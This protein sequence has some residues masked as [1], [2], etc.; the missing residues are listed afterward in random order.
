MKI[1]IT[2]YPTYGGSGIIATELG[3]NLAERGHNVHFIS[4]AMP[5]RLHHYFHENLYFHEVETMKY[6]L[7][8]HPPYAI[9]LA[10][11]MTDI[12]RHE[13][14]DLLHVHYAIPHATSAYLA[15]QA[16]GA[17]Q[18]KVIT[19]LH[20]TDI[21]IVGT[22]S[23]FLPITQFSIEK[24]DGVTTISRW[25]QQETITKLGINRELM[26][27]P[28]FIDTELFNGEIS[29]VMKSY[30]ICGSHKVLIHISNFRPVKRIPDVIDIFN[31]VQKKVEAILLMVGD[32]PERPPA[33]ARC[34]ELGICQKVRFLG[35][36]D[37]IQDLL[38]ISDV[39]LF[40]S[41]HESFGIAALEAMS[42]RVPVVASKAGG[43]V[44][45]VDHGETGYLVPVGDVDTMAECAIELLQNEEQ[46][47]RI[48]QNGR[49]AALTRFSPEVIVPQYEDYYQTVLNH[50]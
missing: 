3:K 26:V 22:D 24:S 2:C 20:G 41:E 12:V 48:G 10:A 28:N 49:N 9:S 8:E 38:A 40:P 45:V 27:I 11:K 43:L 18:L 4:Y 34:R 32:G 35:K 5:P 21:T 14:L 13:K 23:S 25:L 30:C 46:C 7:F 37:G 42:C 36:Q 39:L 17:D 6:P 1:G 47:K 16:V 44:E 50:S 15:Q 31:R 29:E 19:T 33:E